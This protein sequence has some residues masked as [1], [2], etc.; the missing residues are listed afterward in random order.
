MNGG[1]MKHRRI[2][3]ALHAL[4]VLAALGAGGCRTYVIVAGS[5]TARGEAPPAE[6]ME[7]D[8]YEPVL[9]DLKAVAV[10]FPN[11]CWKFEKKAAG[12]GTQVVASLTPVCAP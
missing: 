10:R 7:T 9:A 5:P 3:H 8:A 12:G 6:V 11:D 2:L 4:L 1:P